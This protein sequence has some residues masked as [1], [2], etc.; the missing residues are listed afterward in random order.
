MNF[1]DWLSDDGELLFGRA[2]EAEYLGSGAFGTAYRLHE[3]GNVLKVGHRYC[4]TSYVIEVCYLLRRNGHQVPPYLPEVYAFERDEQSERWFAHME[5]VQVNNNG[6]LADFAPL[7]VQSFLGRL[8]PSLWTG[9]Y[10]SGNWGTRDNGDVVLFD[11]SG[12]FGDECLRAKASELL[13]HV[14]SGGSMGMFLPQCFQTE[15]EDFRE[16]RKPSKYIEWEEGYGS[17]WDFVMA[18]PRRITG[19]PQ[20]RPAFKEEAL[21][22]AAYSWERAYYM[23]RAKRLMSPKQFRNFAVDLQIRRKLCEKESQRLSCSQQPAPLCPTQ[24][25]EGALQP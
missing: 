4:G 1:S 16:A 10:H 6:V 24:E 23:D 11:P 13:E 15:V 19:E 3:D 21:R 22:N 8:L 9:D 18:Y 14:R 12:A 25:V 2:D 7:P 5:F 20:T 17:F